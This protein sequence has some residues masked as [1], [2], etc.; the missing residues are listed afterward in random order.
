MQDP[1]SYHI[2]SYIAEATNRGNIDVDNWKVTLC[3]REMGDGGEEGIIRVM[4]NGNIS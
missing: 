3:V 1:S 4:G 2:P